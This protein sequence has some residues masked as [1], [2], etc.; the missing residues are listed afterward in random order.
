MSEGCVLEVVS[1]I[2]QL[3]AEPILS[4]WSL[5]LIINPQRQSIPDSELQTTE[6]SM[7]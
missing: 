2:E 1:Y 5:N 4:A 3:V 6:V 7:C